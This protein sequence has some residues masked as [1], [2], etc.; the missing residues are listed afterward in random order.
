MTRKK[1]IEDAARTYLCG[2]KSYSAEWETRGFIAGAEW[3]DEHPIH[4]DGQA[5]L[6]VLQ[7][8]VKQGKKQAL[9][10]FE[11]NRLEHCDNITEEQY[12][13]ESNFVSNHLEK[14]H[15][16]PTILDAIE[17]GLEKG[18]EEMLD[19]ACNWLSLNLQML[20]NVFDVEYNT[21]DTKT[22]DFI[23][24]FRKAMEE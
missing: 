20:L 7:K 5:M 14:H 10:E 11:K 22:E 16:V 23:N 21:N 17:Y 9:E 12:N 13:L 6:Y 1:E 18:K 24:D 15:R 19:K 8:G 3:A 4:Y 2:D